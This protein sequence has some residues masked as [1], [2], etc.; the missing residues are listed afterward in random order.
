MDSLP[1]HAQLL[2]AIDFAARKHVNQRRKDAAKTPYI[3]HP[4]GVAGILTEE[5][6]VFDIQTLQ[7]AVLHDTLEDTDT[8]RDEL[9][10]E[11]G[12]EVA[13]IV[14]ECTDDKTLPK[15]ER[16]S[17]Q[18]KNA[19]KKSLKA[20]HVKLADKLYN[21]RDLQR[22]SP[23]GWSPQRVSEY[24]EW[25]KAVVDGLR[26]SNAYLEHELDEVFKAGPNKSDRV[27]ESQ[28]NYLS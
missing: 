10:Q 9:V 28:Q 24:F 16:K 20:K 7:A 18:V 27:E 5:G 22:T 1:L 3:N 12:E 19:P 6:K 4:I 17:L 21:L 26:G 14:M 23:E 11:F 2:K 8:T 15:Q 13:R 25:A